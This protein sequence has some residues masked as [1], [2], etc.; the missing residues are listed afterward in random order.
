MMNGNSADPANPKLAIHP[1][2]PV[3][4]HDGRSFP[5]S[6]I[7]IGYI[8]PRKKPTRDTA[9]ASPMRD[10]TSHTISS[11]LKREFFQELSLDFSLCQQYEK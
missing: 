5:V 3:N 10:G 4:N 8:G 9:I 11:S 7:S 1:M 6:F 2:E